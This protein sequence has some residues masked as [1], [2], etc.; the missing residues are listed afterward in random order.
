M[1]SSILV[2][3]SLATGCVRGIQPGEPPLTEQVPGDSRRMPA[4]WEA[5]AA[6]W[7]QWPQSWEGVR[8]ERSFVNIVSAIA[9]Y[10]EVHLIVDDEQLQ[11]RAEGALAD[12]NTERISFHV[13][14]T[15]SSW[16]RDNGPRYVE[17]DGQLVMQDWEF[18]GWGGGLGPV[19]YAFDSAIPDQMAELLDL[20]IESVAIVH[21][22][23]DLEVNGLDT[24]IVSWSVLSQ[25]NPDM[26][27]E[28][29]SQALRQVLGVSSVV[30]IEGFDP[31]DGTRG[32]V[33]GMVRFVSEDTVLVGQDGSDLM[34]DV[35]AQ[36]AE[37]RPD[38]TIERLVAPDAALLLNF[39][40]GDDFVLVGDPQ[41]AG[42]RETAEQ[43]L[44]RWFPGREVR[45]VNVDALWENGGG[46]HC[47]TNDQ[48]EG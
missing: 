22:R 24:A 9:E 30:Y 2:A 12:A 44:D 43:A 16:L 26:E 38:L 29:M 4:E 48:P 17:V 8:V 47:V 19:P 21:E 25:R 11:D 10:E 41:D 20:P 13:M 15:D 39:L 45:F 28:E 6:V 1:R 31:Q 37:Q 40:V 34:D 5:Q 27:K 36:I 14:R 32:H 18:D 7:L 35:A 46:V 23:G 42:Q 3:L 33:D